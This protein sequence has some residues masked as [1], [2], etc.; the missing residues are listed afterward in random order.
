M[1]KVADKEELLRILN[2]DETLTDTFEKRSVVHKKG[3]WHQ[4]F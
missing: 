1:K 3:L 2:E 4:H